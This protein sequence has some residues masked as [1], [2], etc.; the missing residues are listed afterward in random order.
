MDLPPAIDEGL[1]EALRGSIQSKYG[2]GID[3]DG[4]VPTA[5]GAAYP[6]WV[7]PVL[8]KVLL[9]TAHVLSSRK[10]NMRRRTGQSTVEGFQG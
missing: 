6:G 10:T 8:W 7:A 9:Q 4:A 5:K 2:V 1:A 3:S